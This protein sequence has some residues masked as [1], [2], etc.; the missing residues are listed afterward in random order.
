MGVEGGC[1]QLYVC[2]RSKCI[3]ERMSCV[4]CSGS[5]FAHQVAYGFP[6]RTLLSLPLH[7]NAGYVLHTLCMQAKMM[8][9]KPLAAAQV[10]GT[11]HAAVA[12]NS[13]H[14]PHASR[15]LQSAHSIAANS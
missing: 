9:Q 8:G 11:V 13:C 12:G 5:W 15:A 10:S 2:R 7:G 3:L 1:S 6:Y 4:T 14:I